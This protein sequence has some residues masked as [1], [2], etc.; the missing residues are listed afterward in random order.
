ML[1]YV[2]TSLYEI[3]YID[4]VSVNYLVINL[5]N[6]SI[7]VFVTGPFLLNSA[8]YQPLNLFKHGWNM[9][10]AWGSASASFL[11][12]RRLTDNYNQIEY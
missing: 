8:Q 9:V 12:Y 11:T 7:A 3:F 1:N 10:Y 5:M 6:F 2:G 4:E